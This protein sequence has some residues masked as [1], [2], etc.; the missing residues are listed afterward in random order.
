MCRSGPANADLIR[1]C[2]GCKGKHAFLLLPYHNSVEQTVPDA[3]HT[4]RDAIVNIFELLIG[5]SDTLSCRKCEANFG[6]YFGMESNDLSKI[7]RKDPVVSYSLSTTEI[8]QADRICESIFT[9]AHVDFVPK[10]LF[11]KPSGLKSHDWKQVCTV[12]IL[13][14][15]LANCL[16]FILQV[17]SQGILKYCLRNLLGTE[18]RKAVLKFCEVCSMI[19]LEEHDRAEVHKLLEETNLALAFLEKICLLLFRY[20]HSYMWLS[21]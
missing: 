18:Q 4:I 2:T 14:V 9:P 8:Q 5:K 17:A 11:S 19:C 16:N 13:Y 6:R 12:N 21:E 20:I 7:S 1:K 10:L 15:L 3:M